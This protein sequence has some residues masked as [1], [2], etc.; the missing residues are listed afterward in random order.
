MSLASNV[1]V[2]AEKALEGYDVTTFQNG[3]S[4]ECSPLSCN[5]LA[6]EVPTNQHCLLASF[7]QAHRLL[8]AG[9]FKNSEPGPF[10]ILA[11][12]STPWPGLPQ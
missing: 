11:V 5:S 9:T 3:N 1:V 2:P 10:R 4:P 6:E 12:Y 7:E 8:E